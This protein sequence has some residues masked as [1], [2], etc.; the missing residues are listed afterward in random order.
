MDMVQPF[1][2]CRE[3]TS[4]GCIDL[5]RLC[6]CFCCGVEALDIAFGIV[7]NCVF[8]SAARTFYTH[9]IM[10]ASYTTVEQGK[11]LLEAGLDPMTADMKY[12]GCSEDKLFPDMHKY[13]PSSDQFINP[14]LPCWSVARLI[15]LLPDEI[16]M[17]ETG[18]MRRQ[19]HLEISKYEPWEYGVC[20]VHGFYP[21]ESVL[22]ET[23]SKDS[24]LDALVEMLC[25]V[26]DNHY[27]D[28]ETQSEIIKNE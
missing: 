28:T 22:K 6:S 17:C 4:R 14:V 20:Y 23:N 19:Y 15:A 2:T 13:Y 10:I 3:P 24:P 21:D 26:M 7:L 5:R 16:V 27:E 18:K 25:W 8:P 9:T 11:A 12:I 1:Y